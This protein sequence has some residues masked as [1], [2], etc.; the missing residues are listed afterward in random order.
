MNDMVLIAVREIDDGKLRLMAAITLNEDSM[1]KSLPDTENFTNLLTLIG[2][3]KS[4][5]FVE[6]SQESKQKRFE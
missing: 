4:I 2:D 1:V 6:V 5:T 3:T